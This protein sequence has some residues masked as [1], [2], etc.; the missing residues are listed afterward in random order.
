MNRPRWLLPTA[1]R[2]HLLALFLGA[3]VPLSLAPL[4]WWPLGI[5]A[6]T[7]LAPLLENLGGKQCL[8]RSFFF[9]LGMFG[10]GASWVYISI[11]DFGFTSP[12]LA[13]LLTTLFVVGLALVFALPFIFYSRCFAATLAGKTLGFAA[14]WTLGEWS[15]SWLLT[16]F[17]WLYLG[18]AHVDTWLAGWAPVF[19]VF[20]LS[21]LC[22]VSGTFLLQATL[23]LRKKSVPQDS[24]SAAAG[25]TLAAM[26]AVLWGAGFFLARHSWQ[27]HTSDKEISVAIVQPNIPLKLKWN[28]LYRDEI[29]RI[30]RQ[31]TSAH[32]DKD[33]IVWPEAAVPLMYHDAEY[34]LSEV[35][36]EAEH[37]H[38]GIILGILYDDAEPQTY[39][40]SIVGLGR[41][42]GIYFKQRLVPFGEYVPLE[43]WLRGLIAF[44]NLPNSII[45]PGPKN[46]DI[47]TFDQYRVAPSI[48]YEIV[49]P[50]LVA[51]LARDAALLVTIS[52]DAWFGKSIGP[53]Q[54]FQMA[55]M[56]ALE[57][58]RYVLRSTNTGVSGIIDPKGRVER[59][60]TQFNQETIAQ[61]NVGLVTG[62]TPFSMWG[63]R[64]VI[65][66]CWLLLA[67]FAIAKIRTRLTMHDL[68]SM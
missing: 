12:P 54:H 7:L 3:L 31:E 34:F 26:V 8:G 37:S 29:M 45:F 35:A 68:T 6:A 2:G 28:P 48:C 23:A 14:I 5:L 21:F 67:G 17:P 1:W 53:H 52:N 44:F 43:R 46:Q 11:H 4:N 9:G 33:L 51:T 62:L 13:L 47:L 39:Y 27:P 50:N 38:S 25:L 41:A 15:R 42:S 61:V 40:N 55:R 32:W 59:L 56:R 22:L 36:R 20:G 10:T 64:P 66:G 18:Y 58:Q 16:G 49:Y 30:L 63:S 24:V 65:I 57:N 19:G 60:A